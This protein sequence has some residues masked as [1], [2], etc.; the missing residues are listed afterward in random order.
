M[1]IERIT[2]PVKPGCRNA[3]IE[4]V[5]ALLAEAGLEPRVFS[6]IHGPMDVVTADL[7]FESEDKRLKWWAGIDWSKPKAV[8]WATKNTELVES[9]TTNQL[10][11]VH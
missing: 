1:V 5:K 6:F 9:G 10:L 8:E 4:L 3:Y 11:Q 7:V 2:T